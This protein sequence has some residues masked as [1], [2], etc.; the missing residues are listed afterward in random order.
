MNVILSDTLDQSNYEKYTVVN[1][2]EEVPCD[3]TLETLV[4]HSS[5]NNLVQC[6]LLLTKCKSGGVKKYIYISQDQKEIIKSFVEGVGGLIFTEEDYLEEEN[7]DYLVENYNELSGGTSL[8]AVESINILNDFIQRFI[9]GDVAVNNNVY[10]ERVSTA[11]SEIKGATEGA[12]LALKNMSDSTIQLFTE[13]SQAFSNMYTIRQQLS[14]KLTMVQAQLKSDRTNIIRQFSHDSVNYYPTVNYVGR[15]KVLHIKE[16]SECRYLLSFLMG[17]QDYLVNQKSL[18][19]KVILCYAKSKDSIR[20]YESL[21]Q[22]TAETSGYKS[23]LSKPVLAVYQPKKDVIN[24]VLNQDIDVFIV[25]DR[26]MNE[27]IVSG[28]SVQHL[29]AVSGEGSIKRFKLRPQNCI[30]P[31]VEVV[32]SFMTIPTI[33]NYPYDEQSRK[34]AYYSTCKEL[35]LRLDRFLEV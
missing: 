18:K 24:A 34:T 14:D 12:E 25:L 19:A 10:Q 7:L 21:Y 17:Y 8:V 26:M 23:A 32:N 29:H 22:L 20:R 15:A 6:G 13:M 3:G 28:A 11:L 30:L 2:L 5:G 33:E 1:K 35:Y 16:N 9:R 27:D 4:I 31:I